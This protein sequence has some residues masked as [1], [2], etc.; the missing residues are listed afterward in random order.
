MLANVP[1]LSIR[2]QMKSSPFARPVLGPVTGILLAGALLL[3]GAGAESYRVKPGETLYRIA[4]NAGLSEETVQ[5]ANPVL[6]GGHALY[7]GQMLT[8]PPK[9]LPPGTFRVRKGEDLKKLAQRLGVSEGDIRRD[10]PQIDRRGSLNAGQVLRLPARLI[11]AQRAA[12][13]AAQQ[14]AAQQKAAQAAARQQA[15]AKKRAAQLAAAKKPKPTTH[16][17]EIGD[18]FYSVARRYGINPIALQEYNPRLAGQTLNVG[19]VLS[20]VAPPL[21]PA[22][23]APAR[24]APVRL[25]VARPAPASPTPAPTAP[26][27]PAPARPAPARPSPAQPA[28]PR[29]AQATPEH[30]ARVVVRQTSSHSLWQWPLP[31]Y[32]R[33]TSDFGWR[34]LDGEREKHQGIDVAAPPGTPVIAARSGRVIQAHLDETYG[35]GWTVVIQHPDGWQTRYAHLSR[36]SVEAG[37]L[38]RQGERVGAVGSTGRVTGPHLHFGLYRNWDPHNPLAFYAGGLD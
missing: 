33:I 21:R 3:G 13:Q 7:A 8:I 14:K 15:A 11:A 19:A 38:V 16:R 17:V 1:L 32:G 9:P 12:E 30:H 28:P 6:R 20:L 18:T 23:V 24:P 35:W 26:A 4:L 36:I 31:G 10:N 25:V 34:V 29:V 5:Q 37:Q 2:L 27:R 22:P